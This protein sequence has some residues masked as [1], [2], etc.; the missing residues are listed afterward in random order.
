MLQYSLHFTKAFC[1]KIGYT[2]SI[3]QDISIYIFNG[4]LTPRKVAISVWDIFNN[5][6]LYCQSCQAKFYNNLIKRK[7]L[8]LQMCCGLIEVNISVELKQFLY[9]FYILHLPHPAILFRNH[10]YSHCQ[11]TL[12]LQLLDITSAWPME[13]KGVCSPIGKVHPHCPLVCL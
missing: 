7:I 2:C 4:Q 10:L 8:I 6:L 5:L 1:L 3:T 13:V 11:D 12:F 9:P